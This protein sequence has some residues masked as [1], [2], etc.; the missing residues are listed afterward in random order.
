MFNMAE[1]LSTFEVDFL[2]PTET[3]EDYYAELL[4]KTVMDGKGDAFLHPISARTIADFQ[5]KDKQ[6]NVNWQNYHTCLQ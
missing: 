3:Y 6:L 2:A 1:V 4:D 5:R